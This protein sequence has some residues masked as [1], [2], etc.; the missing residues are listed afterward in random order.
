MLN[1]ITSSLHPG[2]T[3]GGRSIADPQVRIAIA[4]KNDLPSAEPQKEETS[5]RVQALYRQYSL[6]AERQ[7]VFGAPTYVL[8]GESF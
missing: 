2:T 1:C 8:G 6:E 4:N 3:S 7:G 5:P